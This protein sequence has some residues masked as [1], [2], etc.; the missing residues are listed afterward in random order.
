MGDTRAIL[1]QL[2]SFDTTSCNSNLALVDWAVDRFQRLGARVRLTF[3]DERTKANIL[4]SLG[5]AEVPGVVLS[6]HTDVVPVDDQQWSS[7]PF[8]LREDNGRL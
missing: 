4:A 6:G 7:D 3:D 2:I 1:E 5:P 8:I